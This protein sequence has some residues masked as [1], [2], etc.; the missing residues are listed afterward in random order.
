MWERSWWECGERLP[1]SNACFDTPPNTLPLLLAH[2]FQ[3]AGFEALQLPLVEAAGKAGRSHMFIAA[4][5]PL[6]GRPA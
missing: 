6:Q 3:R 2:T 4:R 5:C 1:K